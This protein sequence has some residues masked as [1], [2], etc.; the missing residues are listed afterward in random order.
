M[1]VL[2]IVAH[3][4]QDS[5]SFA[6]VNRYQELALEKG[7]TIEMIDLYRTKYQQPFFTFDD[8]NNLKQTPEK[9]FFQ[10]KIIWAD[11]IVFVFPYWWGSMPAILK[12]FIDWNFSRGFGFEY[13]NSRPRG[14]LKGKSV[15]VYTTTGAPSFYYII[16]GA[17]KRLRKMWQKQIIE[18]CGMKLRSFNIYGGVDKTKTNTQEILDKMSLS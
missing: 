3:P 12:N 6:M 5:F 7:Y 13:V 2:I 16:T 1:N 15:S 11:E 10:G 9:D 17:N 18:F 14:L 4:K 8:A